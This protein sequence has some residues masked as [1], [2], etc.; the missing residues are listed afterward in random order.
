MR[1]HNGGRLSIRIKIAYINPRYQHL[2]LSQVEHIKLL[3]ASE[4]VG[5]ARYN[6]FDFAVHIPLINL[7]E[8]I[9]AVS[10]SIFF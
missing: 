8:S 9:V 7:V 2:K 1:V 6:R 3:I 10:L 5:L 4:N